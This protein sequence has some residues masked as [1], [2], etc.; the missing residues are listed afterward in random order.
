MFSLENFSLII[1]SSFF[2]FFMILSAQLSLI[3]I[4]MI[5][6][7]ENQLCAGIR[8]CALTGRAECVG[9]AALF[10]RSEHTCAE[11]SGVAH[12]LRTSQS[13]H[14]SHRVISATSGRAQQNWLISAIIDDNLS[15]PSP[16]GL[17]LSSSWPE[18]LFCVWTASVIC[19]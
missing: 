16:S 3:I 18:G 11:E 1:F 6:K 9:G 7:I 4:E 17:L 10:Y 15:F 13:S 19:Q 8:A 2:F 5:K 14:A 12:A